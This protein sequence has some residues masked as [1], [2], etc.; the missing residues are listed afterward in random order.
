MPTNGID[1][2]MTHFLGTD[3]ATPTAGLSDADPE[4]VF[5]GS[6]T[7]IGNA[8]ALDPSK[9]TNVYV[10]GSTSSAD[11]PTTPGVVQ[12]TYGGGSTTG[13]IGQASVP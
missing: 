12:V 9:A 4:N 2:H 5:G 1:V 6:G 10:A 11:L 8:V 13:F 3:N 7:D